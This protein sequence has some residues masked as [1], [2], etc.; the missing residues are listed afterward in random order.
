MLPPTSFTGVPRANVLGVRVHATTLEEAVALS[1]RFLQSGAHSYVCLT[2][3]HGVM[4]AQRD[5]QL[6][7]ILNDA[8]LC[9]PDGMPTV[10]VGR[11][12]GQ[13]QMSRVYGPDYMLAMCQ[14]LAGHGCRHFLYGGRPGVVEL[15]QQKLQQKLPSLQIV[16]MYTPPF[17]QL[18]KAQESELQARIAE[19][20]PDILW[21]GLST[22]KQERFMAEHLGKLEVRMMAGVG[23]AFDIHAGLVSDAPTWVKTCGLQW[24]DRLRKEPRRL[25][26]RYF[27]NNPA[28][29]WQMARQAA[30]VMRASVD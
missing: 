26:P 11:K 4:E 19:S 27:R 8:V 2:G 13:R 7:R 12:Q 6:R 17:R 30:G 5:P 14:S 18:S 24:L 21:V 10:W 9:L 25:A 1:S 29:I 23:A 15:L 22:P 20:K 28:F 16:G 3:V